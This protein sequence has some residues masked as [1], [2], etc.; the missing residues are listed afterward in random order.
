MALWKCERINRL[1]YLWYEESFLGLFMVV[2]MRNVEAKRIWM[3][4]I[5]LRNWPTPSPEH[6]FPHI[7]QKS[8]TLRRDV[9]AQHTISLCLWHQKVWQTVKPSTKLF[10]S[11]FPSP[12]N[13]IMLCNS[14][15]PK[16]KSSYLPFETGLGHMT[17]ISQQDSVKVMLH[18]S[19]TQASREGPWMLPFLLL[20]FNHAWDPRQQLT[21]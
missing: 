6:T 9:H 2:L 19:W 13:F 1:W 12:C 21:S 20:D 7:S 8:R 11:L 18:H 17:C 14:F 15:H 10:P 3:C 5:L 16:V 4:E